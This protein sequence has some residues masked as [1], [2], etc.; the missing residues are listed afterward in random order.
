MNIRNITRFLYKV[1]LILF[2]LFYQSEPIAAQATNMETLYVGD[3]SI[4]FLE[5]GFFNLGTSTIVTSRAKDNYG[6]ISLAGA[7]SWIGA[8][9]THFVDGYVQTL[10]DSP[11]FMPIGQYGIYAPVQVR[12][13]IADGINA[14]YFR[15]DPATIGSAMSDSVFALSSLE[16]WDIQG[17]SASVGI[18]L[19]WR[20]SSELSSWLGTDL[21]QLSIVGWDGSRWQ[22]IASSIDA[23]SIQGTKSTL[24]QG[25]IRS[26]SNLNLKAYSAFSLAGLNPPVRSL[27]MSTLVSRNVLHIKSSQRISALVIYDVTGKIIVSEKVD[28][29]FNFDI[30][31]YHEESVY[32]ARIQTENSTISKKFINRKY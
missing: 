10:G 30:P 17:V 13:T 2:L 22:K 25:S 8:S 4:L 19:S 11:F 32:I 31:F 18:S 3:S 29:S 9:D 1:F 20:P 6:L 7:S 12:P 27:E 26:N 23:I 16:Y 14:A 5:S 15:L 28:A 21:K 24:S